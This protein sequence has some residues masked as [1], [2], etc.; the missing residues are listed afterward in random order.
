M[1]CLRKCS[2]NRDHIRHTLT[3]HLNDANWIAFCSYCSYSTNK[4]SAL[5]T[6]LKRKHPNKS[7]ACSLKNTL[8]QPDSDSSMSV[9][10]DHDSHMADFEV[11]E[12]TEN[13]S[14]KN[15]LGKYFL[16][17][18]AVHKVGPTSVN[19]IAESTKELFLSF[20]KYI[21]EEGELQGIQLPKE[22]FQ[23]VDY[24]IESSFDELG[25][26]HLRTKFY[27]DQYSMVEPCSCVMGR[28][29]VQK[30]NKTVMKPH[31]GYYIPLEK[32]LA[33][34][35]RMP[36]VAFYVKNSHNSKDR[37][38]RDVC[39]AP[40]VKQHP[41]N[42]QPNSWLQLSMSYDDLEIVNPLR[43]SRVHKV[44]VL[45]FNL[46]NIPPRFRSKLHCIFLIAVA[47]VK[48]VQK[49]GFG[50][51][52]RDFTETI[53]KLREQGI[54]FSIDSRVE[55][56]FGDLIFA[57]CD[58]PAA[59]LLGGFKQSPAW[60]HKGCRK[61]NATQVEMK[62][63][64]SG[65]EF[66]YR[67][68]EVHKE[69]CALL[70][71]LSRDLYPWWSKR[72]GINETSVL[73]NIPQFPLTT[74][75]LFDNMH[76]LLEGLTP[77]I[78]GLFLNNCIIVDKL[79]TLEWLNKEL[80][81]YPYSY[82][83]S[84]HKPEQI[85]KKDLALM[86]L[87][88]KAVAMKTLCVIIPHILGPVFARNP[89]QHY[90]HLIGMCQLVL[91]ITSPYSAVDTS[92]ELEVLVNW[93]CTQYKLLYPF[94]R[95]YPKMHFL[96][97]CVSELAALGPGANLSCLKFEAKH[98]YFK[99]KRWKN[100]KNVPLSMGRMHQKSLVNSMVT[101]DGKMSSNFVY[102]GD[103]VGEGERKTLDMFPIDIQRALQA[104]IAA[105]EFYEMEEVSIHGNRYVVGM[106]LAMK[107]SDI[108]FPKFATIDGLF[109]VND[110]KYFL[111]K[112]HETVQYIWQLNAYE[113]EPENTFFVL[114]FSELYKV[115]PLDMYS[116]PGSTTV[117][118]TD[119]YPHTLGPL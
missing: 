36:E 13:I 65:N 113:V 100:F 94:A 7:I 83:D 48:S 110:D 105:T 2:S 12:T 51:L 11:T 10:S 117:V 63:I 66:V 68:L 50:V 54:N 43:S 97:H 31:V 86:R 17:L 98:G 92:G 75:L 60:A 90:R 80:K 71:T 22:I 79:F 85:E 96:V 111:L 67:D 64:F 40:Y 30:G 115:K 109:V 76:V 73:L 24:N 9:G 46:L 26:S 53:A 77:Q 62:R 72:Y 18:E 29:R 56:I 82:I 21:S 8:V 88:Q 23:N 4:Y 16:S 106:V 42:T 47:R 70:K 6:H 95:V 89:S 59:A 33:A 103:I 27:K 84:H 28:Q 34:L 102:K 78:F 14:F 81:S 20:M 41:L 49:Y 15:V 57:T 108:E 119:R 99:D 45:Y 52:L 87:R 107:F 112:K 3:K 44:S 101:A 35:L 1:M 25:T 116:V 55:R 93:Y 38:I 5:K 19:S 58:N 39:D 114:K 61:C 74:N 118:V 37:L 91:A 32:Q 104:K 69:R